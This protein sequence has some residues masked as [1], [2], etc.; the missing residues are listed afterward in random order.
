M[1]IGDIKRDETLASWA[2][3]PDLNVTAVEPREPAWIVSVD[4]RDGEQGHACCPVCDTQSSSRHSSYIRTLRD[5]S[6]Q[7]KPVII[8]APSTHWRCRNH[9]C[10][11]RIFAER[12][13]RLLG[14]PVSGTKILRSVRKSVTTQ[15]NRTVIRIV[16]VDEWSWRKGTTFGTIIVDL[17]RRQVW[18]CWRIARPLPRLAGSRGIRKSKLSAVIPRVSVRMPCVRARVRRDRSRIAFIC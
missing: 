17:E 18:G 14:M 3:A 11:R 12:L 16:G 6:A 10:D 2:P 8:Q 4:G 7:G 9:E 5:L 1:S 13:P 15:T